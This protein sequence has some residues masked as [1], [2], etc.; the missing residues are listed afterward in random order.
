MKRLAAGAALAL[1]AL[2]LAP[3]SALPPRHRAI[4]CTNQHVVSQTD[5]RRYLLC[6]NQREAAGDAVECF[7]QYVT[8]AEPVP[9]T[10]EERVAAALRDVDRTVTFAECLAQ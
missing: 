5:A 9:R 1:A 8:R 2:P 7:R 6:L 4:D 3:A 10:L